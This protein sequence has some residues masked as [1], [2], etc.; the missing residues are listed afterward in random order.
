MLKMK[1]VRAIFGLSRVDKELKGE[2]GRGV[3]CYVGYERRE[4]DLVC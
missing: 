2:R 3:C 1:F 4:E